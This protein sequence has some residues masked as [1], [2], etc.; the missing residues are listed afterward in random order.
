MAP[1]F[2]RESAEL[3]AVLLGEKKRLDLSA[4]RRIGL[5][6]GFGGKNSWRR[7]IAWSKL[8]GVD[9]FRDAYAQGGVPP[10]ETFLGNTDEDQIECDV[11]RSFNNFPVLRENL[12]RAKLRRRRADAANY[13]DGLVVLRERLSWILNAVA[14]RNPTLKYFQG[15]HDVCALFLVVC[16]PRTSPWVALRLI[17]QFS[18]QWLRDHH[19][20]DFQD[21]IMLLK[22]IV[23]ILQ[24]DR[25]NGGPSIV[26]FLSSAEV[27]PFFALPWLITGFAHSVETTEIAQRIYDAILSSHPSFL[28]YA[29]AALV[30]DPFVRDK[31]LE[32]PCDMAD[33]HDLLQGAGRFVKPGVSLKDSCVG[34]ETLIQRA[35][36]LMRN[37]PPSKLVEMK[38]KTVGTIPKS[39][40]VRATFP[41]P[42][43]RRSALTDEAC[44]VRFLGLDDSKDE[45]DD[46]DDDYP[47]GRAVTKNKCMNHCTVALALA[48]AA[49]AIFFSPSV[50]Y[51]EVLGDAIGVVVA[52]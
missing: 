16:G 41:F 36:R 40:I 42:W 23:P 47:L 30:L 52:L 1:P 9:V 34:V 28:L 8:L 6:R 10:K 21:T 50:T 17:E 14:S 35:L 18:N 11:E 45:H 39:S 5:Q 44:A 43:M 49:L 31:L 33:I 7:R 51:Y 2:E 32:L 25:E 24:S 15:Y 12:K 29:S 38:I 26:S 19:G 3:D 13:E 4:L 22:L 46:D 27:E 20:A 37:L 48:F